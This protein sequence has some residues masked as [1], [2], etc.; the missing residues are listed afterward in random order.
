MENGGDV[1]ICCCEDP[2]TISFH[3]KD[4]RKH[5][6]ACLKSG[7]VTGFPTRSTGRRPKPAKE[8]LDI[9]CRCRL[10]DDGTEMIECSICQ[11]WFHLSC[12][13]I[14]QRFL[15]N[16]DLQWQCSSCKTTNHHSPLLH[17]HSHIPLY[18]SLCII[19]ASKVQQL[20]HG[21]YRHRRPYPILLRYW[22]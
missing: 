9:Y 14:P 4:M 8:Y 5:L 21:H 20:K 19:H 13:K 2:A 12:V 11:E 1:S 6:L 17:M 15:T 10:L 16:M 3:Q 18:E 7:E 22:L